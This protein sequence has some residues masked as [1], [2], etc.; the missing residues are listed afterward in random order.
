MGPLFAYLLGFASIQMV[1]GF[2]AYTSPNGCIPT[3]KLVR[4]TYGLQALHLRAS[5]SLPVGSDLA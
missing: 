5:G 2:A 3:L 1:I 4:L